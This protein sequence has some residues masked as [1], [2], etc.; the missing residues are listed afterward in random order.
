M[1]RVLWFYV[2]LIGAIIFVF[3][4]LDGGKNENPLPDDLNRNPSSAQV[5]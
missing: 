1:K 4:M 2:A 5:M 3:L